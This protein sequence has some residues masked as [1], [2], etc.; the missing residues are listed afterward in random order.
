VNCVAAKFALVE[1]YIDS[2]I[3]NVNEWVRLL[4]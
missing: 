2:S 3:H 1:V 4:R